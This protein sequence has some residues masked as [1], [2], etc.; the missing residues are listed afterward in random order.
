MTAEDGKL[1]EEIQKVIDEIHLLSEQNSRSFAVPSTEDHLNLN[2]YYSILSNLY[3]LFQ[4]LMREGFFDDLPKMLVCLL[5]ERQDCGLEAELTKTVSL[6]MGKPFLMFFSSLRSQTCGPMTPD[7]ESR[8]FFGTYLNVGSTLTSAFSG[9]QQLFINMLSNLMLSENLTNV[10]RSLLDS[11]SANVLHFL[12]MLLEIPVDYVRIAL[13]F[14]IE[15]PSLDGQDTC[16]Q[17][18]IELFFIF[19]CIGISESTL[20]AVLL[21]YR[22]SQAANYVVSH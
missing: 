13:E 11:L 21:F 1:G 16:Q 8:S 4:P 22:R 15:V 6:E 3:R 2:T 5:S 10:L 14:G 12:S 18:K 19:E 20:T 7:G 17:G 9:F